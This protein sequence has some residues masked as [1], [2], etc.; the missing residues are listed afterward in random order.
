VNVVPGEALWLNACGDLAGHSRA[1]AVALAVTLSLKFTTTFEFIGTWFA[2]LVGVVVLTLGAV[3]VG[4]AVVKEKEKS[5][6][7]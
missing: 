4:P 6:A 2:K 3:S 1:N 7:I 5:D